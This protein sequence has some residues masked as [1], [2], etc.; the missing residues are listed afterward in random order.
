MPTVLHE[1]KPRTHIDV[2]VTGRYD[3]CADSMTSA[4][5]PATTGRS[6]RAIAAEAANTLRSNDRG[7]MVAA[8]PELYPHQWS[9]D[10]A[11]IAIG[12]AHLSVPRAIAEMT[13]LL[14]AQ[15]KTGMIPHIVF[16]RAP[17]YFP[18]PERWR[19]EV[20]A[21][22]PAG[23]DT[24]GICQ[25]PVHS[26]AV[27]SILDVARRQGGADRRA[28]EEFLATTLDGWLAWHRW[29]A[30]ERDPDGTGLVEIHHS[31]ESGMDNSPRWDGPYSRVH[32][33]PMEPVQRRDT[34]H[35]PDT[36]QRPTDA[37]YTRY[38]WLVDQMVAARYDDAAVRDSVDF[39]VADVFSSALLALSSE[40][41][42]D[43][44][45]SVGRQADAAELAQIAAR[46][47]AGVAT[48]VAPDTGL[49]R[50]RDV[51]ADAWL[52]TQTYA[53]F[54]PLLCGAGDEATLDRQ[55]DLLLG[56]DWCG[57]PGLAYAVPTSTSP[58]AP[59]FDRRRYW[60]GPQWPPLTWLFSWAAAR[61][62]D[63]TIALQLR[64]ESLRQ[65]SDLSF[66]EYYDP[67]TGEPLGSRAQSW[68]A[69]VALDW[70][71]RR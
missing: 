39:R 14:S 57:H 64:E 60:R 25:P 42:A 21:A 9:W 52:D 68:T 18:G 41:L 32:P 30:T 61:R 13:S 46:F 4:E 33:G 62:G 12:L 20:A 31:W 69:A 34:V 29:L 37:E 5:A 51:R 26:I 47:R 63:E 45:A 8:A 7:H 10:T 36:A 65:L 38:I 53:G 6:P 50:D 15:W 17:G 28:A 3:P 35:V 48:T 70:L 49:A 11:F 67:L 55:H 44:A 54:A 58:S 22:R 2:V 27:A 40:V 43:L 71:A 59:Q 16:D 1:H 19:T 56:P 66:A 24:S 23:R